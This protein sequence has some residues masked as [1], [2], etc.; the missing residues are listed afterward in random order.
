MIPFNPVNDQHKDYPDRLLCIIIHHVLRGEKLNV[1]YLEEW[2][3]RRGLECIVC[4]L[5]RQNNRRP[6][7]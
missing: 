5:A 6:N 7:I 2:G 4:K 3:T 1:L